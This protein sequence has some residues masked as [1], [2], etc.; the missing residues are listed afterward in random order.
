MSLAPAKMPVGCPQ[1]GKQLMVPVSAA[2]KQGRCPSCSNVFVL[3]TLVAAEEVEDELRLQPL[4]GDPFGQNMHVSSHQLQ[5][6]APQAY[7]P[8]AYA[9]QT[10]APPAGGYG[11]PTAQP[12]GFEVP[13]PYAPAAYPQTKSAEGGGWDGSMIGGILMM[14]GAVVWFVGGLFFDIIF[15]YPPILFVI[16]LVAFFKGML[17]GNVSGGSS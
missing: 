4:A 2:G 10:Y 6:T 16:G 12:A 8:Q 7:A 5:P 13:N 14:L 1:C 11:Q 15:F 9:P 17:S 3:P